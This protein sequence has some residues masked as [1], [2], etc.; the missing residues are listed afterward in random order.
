MAY[1]P[2]PNADRAL[3][4]V[5]RGRLDIPPQPLPTFAEMVVYLRSDEHRE[6]MRQIGTT[7]AEVFSRM[8]PPPVDTYRLSTRQ[9]TPAA[10]T[11]LRD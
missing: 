5:E 8:K 1:R 11:G 3:H 4:Q 2:Y 6:K 7:V 9:P 10:P